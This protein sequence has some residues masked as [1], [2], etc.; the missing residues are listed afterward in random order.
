VLITHN[1]ENK[2][3]MQEDDWCLVIAASCCSACFSGS[4]HPWSKVGGR[5]D[6]ARKALDA[7]AGW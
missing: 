5:I 1:K 3:H 4:F 7:A 6:K 2:N